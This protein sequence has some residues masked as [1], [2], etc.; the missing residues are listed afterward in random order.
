MSDKE[1][2]TKVAEAANRY[3]LTALLEAVCY[4]D[5]PDSVRRLMTECYF[6]IAREIVR[7]GEGAGAAAADALTTLCMMIEALDRT[8]PTDEPPLAVEVRRGE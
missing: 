8:P 7:T 3:D 2:L 6:M 4:Y 1:R 5:R